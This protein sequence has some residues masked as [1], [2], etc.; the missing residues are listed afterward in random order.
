MYQ[1][2]KAHR[3]ETPEAIKIAI[4]Y[5]CDL[6]K[7]MHIP[8]IEVRGFEADDLIGTIAK[9]VENKTIRSLW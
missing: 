4:P 6:L 2:Y 7:A 8:I 1:E 5:I 3:D 9:R